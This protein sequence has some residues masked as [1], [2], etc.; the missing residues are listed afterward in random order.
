MAVPDRLTFKFFASRVHHATLPHTCLEMG[1]SL[2]VRLPADLVKALD[3]KKGENIEIAITASRA[4]E[5]RNVSTLRAI[6]ARLRK[7]RGR[8]P[9]DYSF[10]RVDSNEK[11]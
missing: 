11:R 7:Y 10:D 3:L 6:L 5:V 9:A 4:I 2:A 8:L 1:D